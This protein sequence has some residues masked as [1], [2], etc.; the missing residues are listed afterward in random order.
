MV[1]GQDE[2]APEEYM[3]ANPLHVTTDTVGRIYLA[4][5][6]LSIRVF[7]SEGN[8]ITRF[9]GRGRG[10]GEF[11]DMDEMT[12]G[13]D[14]ELIALDT[15]SQRITYFYELGES[16]RSHSF[17][18]DWSGGHNIVPIDDSTLAV[19][20]KDYR[21]E[22]GS[23]R[24]EEM[25][26]RVIKFMSRDLDTQYHGVLDIYEKMWDPDLLIERRIAR[27]PNHYNMAGLPGNQLAFTH[28]VF[29]GTLF[30]INYTYLEDKLQTTVQGINSRFS[31]PTPYR[32][33]DQD[34]D[35]FE[36]ARK[37]HGMISGGDPAGSYRYQMLLQSNHL[38]ANDEWLFHFVTVAEG[39]DADYYLELFDAE[40]GAYVGY[41]QIDDDFTMRQ[42]FYTV[43]HPK[44]IDDRNQL[45]FFD[46]SGDVP[47]LR[48]TRIHIE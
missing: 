22:V 6:D 45:Y 4:G 33:L 24:V 8:F 46:R 20:A 34:V 38:F 13:K 2:N 29:K 21:G 7:Y 5:Q 19:T 44:H 40:T 25:D 41:S 17:K 31:N 48:V 1:I 37:V 3:I 23:D 18:S 39:N 11:L 27:S 36:M 10:P 28:R 12:I 43:F 42:E 9:G 16:H 30:M 35:F 47:V 26:N 32:Q 15:R 14:G